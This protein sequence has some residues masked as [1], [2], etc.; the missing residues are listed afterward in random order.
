MI[1]IKSKEY[2]LSS[3][4]QYDLLREILLSLAEYQ[5]DIHSEII[6]LKNQNK[7]Q[8]LRLSRLEEKNNITGNPIEFNIDVTNLESKNVESNQNPELNDKEK[9]MENEED[10]KENK[11]DEEKLTDKQNEKK[12]EK[13]EDKKEEKKEDKKEEKI[14]EKKVDENSEEDNSKNYSSKRKRKKISSKFGHIINDNIFANFGKDANNSSNS[15]LN[16]EL[17]S[18][19]MKSI[20]ENTEKIANLETQLNKQIE[21]QLK[22]AKNDFRKDFSNELLEN[23]S[24]FALIDNRINEILQKSEEHDKIIED[25]SVKTSN[26]DIMKML[27]DSGDGSVDMTKLLVKSLE[28]RVFKKFEIID[29]RYKQEAGEIMRAR[30]TA[31][32]LNIINGTLTREINDL[33]EAVQKI[34]EDIDNLKNLN[35]GFDKKFGDLIQEKENNLNEKLEELKD[36]FENNKK[37]FEENLNV[38]L[39]EY[40]KN[41]IPNDVEDENNKKQNI[42]EEVIN[43][44]EKKFGDLRKKFNDLDNTF[45]LFLKDSNIDEIKKNIKDI[46]FELEQK[47]TKESLKEL[48]NL[49]LGN[50]DDLSDLR[51]RFS[52]L[53]EDT[54]KNSKNITVLTNR[55]ELV[56][57][58][59]MTLK[60]NKYSPQKP[61]FDSSKFLNNEKFNEFLK[62]YNRKIE[63]IFQEFDSVRRDLN[64]LLNSNQVYEKKERIDRL[65]E[66][67]YIQINERKNNAI[68]IKNDLLKQIKNLEVQI[69]AI[70]DELKQKQD[71]YSWIL[72]KQPIKC[73][74]CASCE[75]HIKNE[76]PTEEFISWNK[77]PPKNKN[78]NNRIGRGFSHMLQMMTNDLINNMDNTNNINDNNKESLNQEDLMTKN[79][80]INS[81]N[82]FNNL[83]QNIENN[84]MMD[85]TRIAQIEKL[86]NK[87]IKKEG[88]SSVPKNYGKLKLPKMAE[89]KKMKGDESNQIIDDAKNNVN[90]NSET[91]NSYENENNSPKIIKI[92]KKYGNPHLNSGYL[93]SPPRILNYN[94]D[95]MQYNSKKR[96]NLKSSS[97]DVNRNGSQTIPVP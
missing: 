55:M 1:N 45:K 36:E 82:N 67:I 60:E 84:I 46:Q 52:G 77:Y 65:E 64:D 43:A 87:I 58:N 76:V 16:L 22:K 73:F 31:E 32:N 78:D 21:I 26:F 97:S 48:Y 42:D 89:G 5:N 49:H 4:F 93:N 62:K 70:N 8:D 40:L 63:Q 71:A 53:N 69:K 37:E 41:K 92:T 94:K 10:I 15:E 74:N 30:K 91:I 88:K 7:F 85:Q 35:E 34:R 3:L 28:E 6:A 12:E 56:W 17:I 13:K 20:R 19:M 39:K 54:K 47:L 72:A 95:E 79:K 24:T 2:N 57:G 14:E 90:V 68:K 59:L 9:E 96:R 44:L 81:A 38:K 27:Q 83:P 23:K 61:V 51:E 11:K 33:K 86:S 80:L 75:A 50:S 29:L 66:D 25:L 18:N